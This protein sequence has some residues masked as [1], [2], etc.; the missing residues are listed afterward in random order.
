M[1]AATCEAPLETRRIY[2][3]KPSEK[4]GPFVKAKKLRVVQIGSYP[5]SN[6]GARSNLINI[7]ERLQARGHESIVIDLTPYHRVK[8]PGVQYP[9]TMMEVARLLLETPADVVHLQMGSALT[10]PKLALAAIV[11][12]LPQA[13]KVCTLHL[14]GHFC[15]KKGLRGWRWGAKAMVLRRFDSVIAINPETADFFD[16]VGVRRERMHLITPFPRLRVA[17]S[18]SLSDEVE[19][20]CRRHT[21]L[22]VSVGEFEPGYDLP[23]QF[24]ILSKVRERYPSA[25]L[26][27][28]GS[29]NLQFKFN[30]ARALHQDGNHIEL[31]GTLPEAAVSELIQ[32]AN[33]LL[34]PNP[35]DRDDFAIQEAKKA[36]T[37][38]VGTDEGPR[39]GAAYLTAAGDVEMAAL[40]VLRSL[41]I[42]RPQY[43]D[44]PAAL[45]D[46]VDDMIRL[47]KQLAVKQDEV[48]P[49]RAA[50]EWPSI[51]WGL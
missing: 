45:S 30:Y 8:Q 32:R 14:G 24:E 27:A 50:Y 40:E 36:R 39:R 41:Q 1:T 29:G 15:P 47:Y 51:G 2:S 11:S 49:M 22:I 26:I 31:T 37:P 34:H 43:E 25:G 6:R 42:A 46:G 5:A 35:D 18:V 9:Q 17:E 10:V 4:P 7:H 48:A 33:V 38:V 21:P 16:S 12:K 19:S 28:I 20:F 23:K 13:Q 44:A 3:E